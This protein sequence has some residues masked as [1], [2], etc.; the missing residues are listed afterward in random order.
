MSETFEISDATI[1]QFL[2]TLAEVPKPIEQ[3]ARSGEGGEHLVW[4]INDAYVLR[5]RADDQNDDLLLRERE[6]WN[7]LKVIEPESTAI[8][9]CV[10]LGILDETSR[11]PY[12]LYRKL[13]GVSAEASP[14]CVS[15]A[16]ENDLAQMLV[17]LRKAALE[18]ARAIGVG[19]AEM[20]DFDELREQALQA[21]T[22]LFDN[23]HIHDLA[24]GIDIRQKLQ[25]S[26]A[27]AKVAHEPIL[28]HADIKGEHIFIDPVTGR[29]TG[30]ID[31]SD[32][33][34][35]HP[36]VDVHGV[37]ISIGTTAAARVAAMAGYGR[38]IVA[39]GAFT[40]RCDS[41]I[42]L[43]AILHENDDSPEWLVRLQLQRALEEMES[44]N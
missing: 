26:D 21:W 19:D 36:A 6:I 13:G 23:G 10:S 17:L 16:T 29:L 11:R 25:L 42:C 30:V 5:V 33:C 8:P 28:L 15:D 39:R 14:Q 1:R 27:E 3:L 41:I 35:G 9:V 32:A 12:G 2:S 4:I 31:W 18:D 40:A 34:I 43:D 24:R 7:L 22:R 38:D 37:A 44:E 20:V